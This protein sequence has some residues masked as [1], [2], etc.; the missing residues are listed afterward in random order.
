MGCLMGQVSWT[1]GEVAGEDDGD[2]LA[3]A[4]AA[5]PVR[6]CIRL[7]E[8]VLVAL[9][10]DVGKVCHDESVSGECGKR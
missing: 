4:F 7:H 9:W 8:Y 1:P 10:L 3:L 5:Y 6:T 2:A